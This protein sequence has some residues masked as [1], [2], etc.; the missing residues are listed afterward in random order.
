MEAWKAWMAGRSETETDFE[1]CKAAGGEHGWHGKFRLVGC[2][3]HPSCFH[4][5]KILKV[6]VYN[7]YLKE[8]GRT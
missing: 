7:L 5:Q 1:V 2:L 8:G 3:D 6:I 4:A